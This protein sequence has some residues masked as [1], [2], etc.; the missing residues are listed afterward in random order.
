VSRRRRLGLFAGFV[1]ILIAIWFAASKPAAPFRFLKSLEPVALHELKNPGE[2]HEYVLLY[3]FKGA[4]LPL[5]SQAKRELPPPE[6][7]LLAGDGTAIL[8]RHRRVKGKPTRVAITE[9]LR[10][11]R[12]ADYWGSLVGADGWVTVQVTWDDKPVFD[13]WDWFRSPFR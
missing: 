11:L 10:A 1:V 9:D 7:D 12:K 13:I 3:T 4:Y 2:P 6:W 5:L 8:Y